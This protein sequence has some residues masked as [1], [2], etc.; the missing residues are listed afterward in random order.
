MFPL[1]FFRV[2]SVGNV[3]NPVRVDVVGLWTAELE[4]R[5]SMA[6]A[7]LE[8]NDGNNRQTCGWIG[9]NETA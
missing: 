4:A 6:G 7:I 8:N 3:V 1:C 9:A 2:L 5:K